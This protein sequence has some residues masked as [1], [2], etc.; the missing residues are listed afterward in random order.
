MLLTGQS[1]ALPAKMRAEGG[2]DR[3]E[4]GDCAD[5]R[6]AAVFLEIRAQVLVHDGE[7][8]QARIELDA[9]DHPVELRLGADHGPDMLDRLHILSP[10]SASRFEA[11]SFSDPTPEPERAGPTA[12]TTLRN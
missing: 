5:L 6:L 3:I 2:Y 9:G 10:H 8:H 1:P 12:P 11:E 7:K 4:H